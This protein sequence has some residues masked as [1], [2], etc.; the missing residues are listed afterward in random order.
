VKRVVNGSAVTIDGVTL[1][2]IGGAKQGCYVEILER[3]KQQLDAMLSHHC[4]ILVLR[5]D[6]SINYYTPMNEL[7]SKFIRKVRKKLVRQYGFTRMGFIWA[8]EQEK[9][10][11]QHYHFA[12]IVDAN[13]VRHPHRVISIC[14]RIAEAWE[15]RLFTPKHCYYQINRGDK[16]GY[17]RAYRRLSYLAKTRGKGYKAGSANDYSSSRIKAKAA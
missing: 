4:K 3:T 17:Q 1:Q 13:K 6:L 9:A 7:I 10:K 14:V 5:L 12:L 2:I 11:K 15:L 16:L 8:R